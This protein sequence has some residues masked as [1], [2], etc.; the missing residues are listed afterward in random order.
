[1]PGVQGRT[2]GSVGGKTTPMARQY[3]VPGSEA[4]DH[5]LQLGWQQLEAR[6]KSVRPAA[7]AGMFYPEARAALDGTVRAYLTRA[8]RSVDDKAPLPKALIVPH[9]GYVYSGAIAASAYAR[10]ARARTTIRRVVLLGPVHR[11]P[12]RGLALP[13]AEAFATPLGKVG[14]DAAAAADV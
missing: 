14:I 1:M 12:I 7:V 6:L 8:A 3:S 10:I 11:V 13:V 9:A 2:S 4:G 5:R